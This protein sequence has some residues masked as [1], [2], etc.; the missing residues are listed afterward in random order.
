V[1]TVVT[2][3]RSGGDFLPWHVQMM[4]RKVEYYSPPGTRFVCLSD[5]RVPGVECI[6][7]EKGWPGWWS[8]MELFRPDLDLG[9]F[10][11][12]DL[13]NVILGSL[14]HILMPRDQF[15]LQRGG[16]TALMHV[17]D[18]DLPGMMWDIFENDPDFQMWRFANQSRSPYG[19]AGFIAEHLPHALYWED[20]LAGQVVNIVEV[21]TPLGPRLHKL[22]ANARVLLCGGVKRR[23]WLLPGF[24]RLYGEDV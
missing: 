2:V 6:A 4:Q 24:R 22:P 8:K 15:V 16:W 17:P 19:D 13:D 21:L 14:E 23:P 7:L 18:S 10:V 12:T 20:M 11:F 5:I 1:A 9:E 3:L